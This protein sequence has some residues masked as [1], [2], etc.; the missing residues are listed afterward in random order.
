MLLL[1]SY[2]ICILRTNL[3]TPCNRLSALQGYFNGINRK[4]GERSI[5]PQV[6][7]AVSLLIP[8]KLLFVL[9][10]SIPYLHAGHWAIAQLTC[11]D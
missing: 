1:H 6:A 7:F 10:E 3:S 11:V 2:N 9:L 8:P 5:A 4:C